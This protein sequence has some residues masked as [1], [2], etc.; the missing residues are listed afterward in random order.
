MLSLPW[1]LDDLTH[2]YGLL[3]VN[4]LLLRHFYACRMGKSSNSEKA[5]LGAKIKRLRKEQG[6]S[7]RTLALMI[8]MDRTYLI[9]VEHG[10]RNIALENIAKIAGGLGVSLSELFEGVEVRPPIP[11]RHIEY[12]A[13]SI[14]MKPNAAKRAGIKKADAKNPGVKGFGIEGCGDKSLGIKNPGVRKDPPSID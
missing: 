1:P 6:L 7:Q 11:L 14:D 8:G 10:K 2:L 13:I 4:A 12:S 5:Q 3:I 9:S